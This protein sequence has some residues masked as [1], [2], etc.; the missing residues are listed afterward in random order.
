MPQKTLFVGVFVSVDTNSLLYNY[1]IH[2]RLVQ[3]FAQYNVQNFYWWLQSP[4]M[5]RILV[6]VFLKFIANRIT[7]LYTYWWINSHLK[8][9]TS[10]N[11]NSENYFHFMVTISYNKIFCSGDLNE[12]KNMRNTNMRLKSWKL[13]FNKKSSHFLIGLNCFLYFHA[14]FV[15]DNLIQSTKVLRGLWRMKMAFF[16]DYKKIWHFQ[17]NRKFY[18]FQFSKW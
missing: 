11:S 17:F 10:N 4:V 15:R 13:S 12:M 14:F 7:M 2:C 8:V 6:F 5:S 18:L 1:D 9:Q 3:Y 16:W